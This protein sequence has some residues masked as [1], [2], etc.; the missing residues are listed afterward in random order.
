MKNEWYFMQLRPNDRA[1]E[2]AVAK[3][4]N[5]ESKSATSIF[6]KEYI[7]VKIKWLLKKDL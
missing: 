6:F 7:L 2:S 1:G 5:R 3:N 4:F